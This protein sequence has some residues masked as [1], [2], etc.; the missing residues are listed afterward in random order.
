MI[1]T[2]NTK[3]KTWPVELHFESADG[4]EIR[5]IT[6]EE[7]RE[8]MNM[9]RMAVGQADR[10]QASET[11]AM[12]EAR[13]KELRAI[14]DDWSLASGV[15]R[16]AVDE[17]L[18]EVERLRKELKYIGSFTGDEDCT[19]QLVAI[20]LTALDGLGRP[21]TTKLRETSDENTRAYADRLPIARV[22]C[23]ECDDCA[24]RIQKE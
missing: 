21:M 22:L 5:C 14:S 13:I 24:M 8:L 19:A 20:A 23:V 10:E 17:A 15:V 1:V 11:K 4:G 3:S 18:D 7:A 2:L 16:N 9:L 12:N 6:I